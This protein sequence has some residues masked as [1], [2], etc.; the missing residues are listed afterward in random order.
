MIERLAAT[1]VRTLFVIEVALFALSLLLHAA[2]LIWPNQPIPFEACSAALFFATWTMGFAIV[3]FRN[4]SNWEWVSEVRQCPGWM[5]K[6]A[7]GFGA[8]VLVVF[9]T[10]LLSGA[11]PGFE[12]FSAFLIAFNAI[13]VC[14]I[15]SSILSEHVDKSNLIKRTRNSLIAVTVAA[16]FVVVINAGYLPLRTNSSQHSFGMGSAEFR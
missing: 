10:V 3:P 15:Y 2:I 13:N 8:Y 7:L 6:G 9:A 4:R 1:Y 11:G 12:T 16:V 5:W 14:L